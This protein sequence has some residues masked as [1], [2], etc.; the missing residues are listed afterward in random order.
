MIRR[1]LSW[2]TAAVV[3]VLLVLGLSTAWLLA[4]ESGTRWL[5]AR[6]SPLLPASLQIAEV[7]GTLVTGIHA[8][9]VS[10]TDESVIIS[11][12]Q[13]DT[14]FELLPLLRRT[15]RINTLDVRGVDVSVVDGPP[16]TSDKA[17]FALDLPITLRIDDA[18]IENIHVASADGELPVEQVL[19]IGQLSGSALQI[20]R[21]DIHS[22]LGDI[23]LAG[24]GRLTGDYPANAT[25]AWELRLQGRPPVSGTVH[26]HGDASRYKVEHN[27]EAPYEVLTTGAIAIVDNAIQV[28]LENTWQ[29]LRVES[30]DGRTINVED[31][32]L[33]L[34]GTPRLLSFD[35]HTTVRSAGIPAVAMTTRGKYDTDRIDF[36]SLSFSNE[37]GRLLAKGVAVISPE[38][39]WEF[40]IE[41]SGLDPA[42][43][44]RRLSGNLQV[45]G[46]TA[47]RMVGQ[48]PFLDL[49]IDD[50]SGDLNGYLVDGAGALSYTNERFQF[51][52]VTV[53]VGDNRIDIDGWY[54]RRLRLNALLQGSDLSQL[55]VGVA[56]RLNG[57]LQIAS[58]LQTFAATGKLSGQRLAWREYFAETL[59]AEFDLPATGK[60][61][62]AL[63]VMSE[64]QG[65]VAVAL[66]GQFSDD[67]WSGSVRKL[68]LQNTQLGDWALMEAA[69][70]SLSQSKFHLAKTCFGTTANV[71]VTCGMLD[72]DVSGP[73]RF[74]ATLDDLSLADLPLG[75]PEGSAIRGKIEASAKGEF[76]NDRLQADASL[77]IDGLGL[78]ATFEGDAVA[79]NF[80]QASAKAAV[81]DNRLVG[82]FELRLDNE[83][84]HVTGNI[85]I[86]DLFDPGSPLLGQGSL[87]LNDLSL[88]S[89][90]YPDVANPAG[91]I[92]S[93]I[94]VSGSLLAPEIVGEAGLSQGSVEVRRAGVAVT[95][96]EVLLRQRE[97]GQLTLQGS[98]KSG[99]GRLQ[100]NGDT[101]ISASSGIRTE[102]RVEGEN[103]SL[104]QL[105]DW[106][107]TASPSISVLFDERATRISGELGIPKASIS[108]H[109][110]PEATERPSP[111]VVVHRGE[112]SAVPTRRQL[113]VDVNTIL[114]EAVFFSG[115][116]LTTGLE[117]SVRIAGG[118][119]SPYRS[120]GRVVLRDGHYK[121]YGQILEIESGELIFNGP[122]TN[123][124]LNVRATRTASD[125]TV[126]GIHLTGTP[127][128]LTSQV[129]S[130]PAL[131]DAEA[132][133]YLLTGRP[134]NNANT[135]EGDMLNQAAFALGLT[136]AGSVVS[137]IRNELGL[138]TLGIQGN[139][140]NRQFFAGKR[141]GNRLFVE[142]AYGMVDS[143]GTLLLR[144]Q[145]N[146]RLA[147]ESRSGSTRL[148]DIIYSVRKP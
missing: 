19:F 145:L 116:G 57:E 18:S 8:R 52:D 95:D 115:F 59:S 101:L 119:R 1:A 87:E 98:A 130:E 14:Q 28:D 114:G 129:Y 148:I 2:T 121:A 71:V 56:G 50:V 83:T 133:S 75:L 62:A 68:D 37:W 141:F 81:V 64:D 128:A 126:A 127:A 112:E 13:V 100:L 70:F 84:D 120:S 92:F 144:Y 16:A 94:R 40:D 29:S 147:I 79:A 146:R 31:G 85:E 65:S 135:E 38:P 138:D 113:H 137:Q 25:A 111:D 61:T 131:G 11:I 35:G 33:L 12:D 66:D 53:G 22:E 97:A 4:T 7:G 107:V 69:E 143:L 34:V 58:D 5:L 60:G 3:A 103:F 108:I 27:L 46:R 117:G 45:A 47:G 10:W 21:L 86:G 73:L 124:A 134:L 110:V 125:K 106:Q 9:S 43:A 139:A 15:V 72:Y 136:T 26:L 91:R 140:D 104:I 88:L 109:T 63:R 96:I 99:E 49:W 48:Q 93:D 105:P 80:E 20:E 41:L 89:F 42:V 30:G 67:K 44:D 54:G 24:H 102:I 23:S 82:E 76:I 142:Y 77:Q 90:F 78:D 51:D 132:L 17:P 36:D 122:L 123:P 55:G 39:T 118:N 74:E 6:V 32:T